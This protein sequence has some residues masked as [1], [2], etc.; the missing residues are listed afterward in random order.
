MHP[1][2]E[3]VRNNKKPF[4]L[5]KKEID[6]AESCYG[7]DKKYTVIR[8]LQPNGQYLV[9]AVNIYSGLAMEAS[10]ADNKDDCRRATK[11]VNRWMDKNARGGKM[12][13]K[14]RHRNKNLKD[15][16]ELK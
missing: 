12:S 6:R 7:S 15:G 2:V 3:K 14:S 1:I 11:E 16:K 8:R 5:S 13:D 9:V 4:K 10:I